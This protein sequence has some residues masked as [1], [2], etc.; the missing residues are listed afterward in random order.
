MATQELLRYIDQARGTGMT[1]AQIKSA[2]LSSGWTV[3]AINEGFKPTENLVV[4]FSENSTDSAQTLGTNMEY[5]GFWIR[6]AAAMIDALVII[7]VIAILGGL[8]AVGI[9]L[10]AKTKNSIFGFVFMAVMQVLFLVFVYGYFIWMTKK[11]GATL[12]KKAMRIKVISDNTGEL[13]WGKVI[14]RETI[15][16]WVSGFIFS[17]GYLL[18]AFDSHKQGLHD[19]IA[20]TLVVFR[21]SQRKVSQNAII[22]IVAG[23]FILILL[24]GMA[25][26]FVQSMIDNKIK[27]LEKQ[28]NSISTP[29]AQTSS[30]IKPEDALAPAENSADKTTE[31]K[32]APAVVGS[33]ASSTLPNTFSDDTYGFSVNYPDNW[34][35]KKNAK[36]EYVEFLPSQSS[37][38]EIEVF[39]GNLGTS[40][41][42]SNTKN[43]AS[44]WFSSMMSSIPGVKKYDQKGFIYN[45]DDGET[46]A[47][48]QWK[49]EME[50][51]DKKVFK[52][53]IILLPYKNTDFMFSYG[54]PI[55]QYD[56]HFPKVIDMLNSWKIMKK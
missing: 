41:L 33:K 34:S 38:N 19:K 21:E 24:G 2:L 15:G 44:L 7:V 4:N 46:L 14:L 37:G 3:A 17:I 1:D 47:G 13:G 20:K 10:I 40:S 32:N 18:V 45:F 27:T 54:A 42:S 9:I 36:D 6:T 50:S 5:A 22:W 56:A 31:E 26:G 11:Y 25:W 39:I 30:D 52:T 51:K 35:Y 49:N 28:E 48:E 23:G 43:F 53:W 29:A 12:G 55:D 8:M 16:K